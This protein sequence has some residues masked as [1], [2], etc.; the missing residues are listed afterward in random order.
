MLVHLHQ[1]P[2]MYDASFTKTRLYPNVHLLGENVSRSADRFLTLK[3]PDGPDSGPVDPIR[4]HDSC[5]YFEK[6]LGTIGYESGSNMGVFR[7]LTSQGIQNNLDP[8]RVHSRTW[9][10]P[11]GPNRTTTRSGE[12]KNIMSQ[13]QKIEKMLKLTR[14]L[15]FFSQ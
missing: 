9:D 13:L 6:M 5:T 3:I 8:D 11:L 12:K 1:K 15:F 10:M 2:A 7:F 4:V 14:I